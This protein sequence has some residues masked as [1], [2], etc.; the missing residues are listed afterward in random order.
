[1]QTAEMR[2]RAEELALKEALPLEDIAMRSRQEIEKTFHELRV[3]QIQ[4]EMQ[5]EELRRAHAELDVTRA[6]YFD[7][8]D[9]APVGYLTLSEQGLILEANLAAATLL[10][11]CRVT[12]TN[13][14]F[15]RFILRDDQ[16]AYYLHRNQECDSRAPQMCELRMVQQDGTVFWAHL[17]LTAGEQ[18]EGAPVCRVVLSDITAHHQV[19][20]SLRESEV[21]FRHLLQDVQGVAVQGYGLDGTTQYWNHASEQLYGYSVREALGRNLVDLIIPAEMRGEVEQARRQMMATGQPLPASELLLMRKDGSRVPVF[22]NHAIV[23]VPGKE[24]ELFCIDIDLTERKRAEEELLESEERYRRLF[25]SA[26]DGVLLVDTDTAQVIQA[27]QRAVELYGYDQEELLTK[28]I[29]DLSAEPLE[30]LQRIYEARQVPDTVI[31]IPQ[32]LHRKK[33]GT[34][35]PL[36]ITARTVPL[37]NQ[38]VLLI[39]GRDITQRRQAEEALQKSEALFRL[40]ISNLNDGFFVIDGHGLLTFG[41]EALGR[42]LGCSSPDEFLGKH[43]FHFT[44]PAA[45]ERAAQLFSTALA[46]GTIPAVV[47]IPILRKD[48]DVVQAEIKATFIFRD[49]GTVRGQGL[50]IDINERKQMEEALHQSEQRRTEVQAAANAQLREQA[51]SL[52]SIYDALDS[53]G[54]I[55]CDLEEDDGRIKIFNTGAEKL[56]GYRQEEAVGKSIDLIYSPDL[57]DRI[58]ARVETFRKGK[59]MQSF[60]MTLKRKSGECFPAVISVH[61]FDPHEG[62]FRKVVGVFRDISELMSAQEQL[63]AAN[64]ELER[65]VEQRTRELQETQAQYLHAEKLSAIG[66]LSASIA[67]EFNNP[68]QGILSILKG[69]RKRA[70]LE[71]EDR[72]LLEAAI[73]ESDRIK[74]LIRSLQEFNRPSSGK[75]ISLDVHKTLNAMLLLHKS[76]FKGKRISVDLN[77]A[78]CLPQVQA[79]PDQIKQVFLNL[80][81]NAADACQQPGGVI[82]VSTWQESD[83]VAV[84]IKDTGIGIPPEEMDL[85]FQPFFTTKPAVKGTGLG[86]SVSYGIV[87]HHHGE[88]RVESS[89]G[90]GATFTVLL[91]VAVGG[92]K[93]KD[94]F[95]SR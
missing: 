91:P 56:F 80:L 62:R 68:L 23:Q 47:E 32:R 35:F 40:L 44:A 27:N 79:V 10:G 12:L 70:I 22:S 8:Y 81:T 53:I 66:K 94:T 14:P 20:E 28:K 13:L 42:I 1:M 36:E 16:D 9:L 43:I 71:E 41:N 59:S 63:K 17:V 24:R 64:V 82:T 21:R 29:T 54:L 3:H 30:T 2:R 34:V 5:N 49:D 48:G 31:T 46:G 76:D 50:V 33:D 18:I 92:L 95:F 69:L 83:R 25:E 67:H 77:Y 75:K 87:K 26:S 65:R 61:P 85:I 37:G 57:V 72:A 45:R 19:E 89:P 39:A 60:D 90:A 51:D 7:L 73:G 38:R 78:E 11:M 86:L 74:D 93:D 4:L 52:T 15:S 6:R 58:P 88:I 55:V 84:A